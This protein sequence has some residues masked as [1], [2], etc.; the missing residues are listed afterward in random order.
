MF[1][2]MPFIV[3]LIKASKFVNDIRRRMSASFDGSISRFWALCVPA[4]FA[5]VSL[6]STKF[7][8]A[9]VV[10]VFS[11]VLTREG[12]ACCASVILAMNAPATN[13]Q[14]TTFATLFTFSSVRPHTARR[15][16]R[17]CRAVQKKILL[18]AWEH[19]L[20][21]QLPIVY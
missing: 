10:C 18:N 5:P 7:F 21:H 2:S 15:L 11:T 1:T 16:N 13:T 8:F 3:C 14:H 17:K 6:T 20:T 9:T 12:F 4:G 19:C